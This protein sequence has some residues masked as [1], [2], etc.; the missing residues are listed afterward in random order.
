MKQMRADGATLIY[1]SH[2]IESVKKLCQKAV[3]LERG[4]VRMQGDVHKVCSAYLQEGQE[5]EN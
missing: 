5:Y 3:W 1:V 2:S 4:M